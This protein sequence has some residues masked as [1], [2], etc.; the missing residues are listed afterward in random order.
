MEEELRQKRDDRDR[1][2]KRQ[3]DDDDELLRGLDRGGV[4]VVFRHG[5]ELRWD[6]IGDAGLATAKLGI[7]S[8]RGAATARK[9][10]RRRG[11]RL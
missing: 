1:H 9:R 2:E 6:G 4:R 5:L 10:A 7:I 11:E 8:M 3:H